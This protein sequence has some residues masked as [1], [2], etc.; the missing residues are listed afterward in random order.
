[1]VPAHTFNPSTQEAEV[2]GSLG[3]RTAWSRVRVPA[4]LGLHRETLYRKTKQN[5]TKQNKQEVWRKGRKKRKTKRSLWRSN[6]AL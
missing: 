4:H 5:E 2:V 6:I 1:M 3:S